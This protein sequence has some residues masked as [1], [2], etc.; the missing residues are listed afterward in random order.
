MELLPVG[1]VLSFIVG[2]AEDVPEWLDG[3][4]GKA[5]LGVPSVI[6]PFG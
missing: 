2:N 4:G 6:G 3:V 5:L 1:L